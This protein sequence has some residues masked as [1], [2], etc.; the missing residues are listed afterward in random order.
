MTTDNLSTMDKSV[1]VSKNGIFHHHKP[2]P[3]LTVI[4]DCPDLTYA[5]KFAKAWNQLAKDS[6]LVFTG[7]TVGSPTAQDLTKATT[8]ITIM[9][10]LG[11]KLAVPGAHELRRGCKWFRKVTKRSKFPWV[12]T[13][14]HTPNVDKVH[15]HDIGG[16]R[17]GFIGVLTAP[18][19]SEFT[20]MD[21]VNVAT[22]TA[23]S[24]R[25]LCDC[26][27]VIS[28]CNAEI[29]EQVCAALAHDNL[30]DLLIVSNNVDPPT[31]SHGICVVQPASSFDSFIVH[32]LANRRNASIKVHADYDEDTTVTAG[33][34]G[35]QKSITKKMNN[36]LVYSDNSIDCR[37]ACVRK[38][39]SE[40]GAFLCDSYFL[41]NNS[42]MD[43]V[44]INGGMIGI[45]DV[46]PS[47]PMTLQRIAD[48][49]PHNTDM[50][51]YEID[52][53][54]LIKL[55][56]IGEDEEHAGSGLN[57]NFSLS[58]KT[59]EN[60]VHDKPISEEGLYDVCVPTF[61][62]TNE[63]YSDIFSSAKLIYKNDELPTLHTCV[64]EYFKSLY[65]YDDLG[66]AGKVAETKRRLKNMFSSKPYLP[67]QNVKFNTGFA[68][69]L[70]MGDLGAN[71][72]TRQRSLEESLS[73]TSTIA[74]PATFPIPY[75]KS[76]T[77][78]SQILLSQQVIDEIDEVHK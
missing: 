14:L 56:Q 47:G 64:H 20:S 23:K 76:P 22:D 17:V 1:I 49:L 11:V 73:F 39:P 18:T 25:V 31:N 33:M 55:I 36:V 21:P 34:T 58:L 19:T 45:D 48:M 50:T 70:D 57:M 6:F 51:V 75:R 9:N 42:M 62:S 43:V 16:M 7:G 63:R 68:R 24:L 77:S 26:V 59:S 71:P 60:T 2:R 32:N 54:S 46:I 52:G 12:A 35:L 28:Q 44:A 66:F 78:K 69:S 30:A 40:V 29:T 27:V 38:G 67:P 8:S 37:E 3:I 74:S 53:S 61:I 65:D 15:I 5:A 10:K 4:G 41:N 13:N 72:H